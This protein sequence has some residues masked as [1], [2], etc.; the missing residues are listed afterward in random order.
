MCLRRCH[1]SLELAID[2]TRYCEREEGSER[3]RAAISHD[4]DDDESERT[5]LSTSSGTILQATSSRISCRALQ[6]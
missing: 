6:I 2:R 5:F 3:Q 1:R 4:D